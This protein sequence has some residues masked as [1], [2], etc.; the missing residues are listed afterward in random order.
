MA[1]GT[2][3]VT[4]KRPV[5]PS[6]T[7]K[8]KAIVPDTELIQPRT[9]D[10]LTEILIL[11]G[12]LDHYLAMVGDGG[13]N[14]RL[15]CYEGGILLVSP[16]I[17]HEQAAERLSAIVKAICSILSISHRAYASSLFRRPDDDKGIEPDKSFY[18]K[19]YEAVRGKTKINLKTDPPPDLV[20]EIADSYRPLKSLGFCREVRVPEFWLY[21]VQKRHLEFLVFKASGKK[22]GN[23]R[24]SSNSLAFPFLAPKDI[25]PWMSIDLDDTDFDRQVRRWVRVELA[26]RVRAQKKPKP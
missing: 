5:K 19:N 25:V 11:P 1:I 9:G 17:A 20:V 6:T 10:V 8:T 22:P 2:S 13:G 21:D 7:A 12:G 4:T 26:P 18:F 14:P 24:G 3:K 23:F 15:K 16:G